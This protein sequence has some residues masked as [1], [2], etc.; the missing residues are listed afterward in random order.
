MLQAHYRETFNFTFEGLQG[1]RTALA[2]IDECIGK[3]REM[4]G[5]I[6]AKP[7]ANSHGGRLLSQFSIALE[8]DLNISRAWAAVFEW[9]RENNSWYSLQQ[10]AEIK[11]I[12]SSPDSIERINEF[13]SKRAKEAAAELTAWEQVNFVL[14][15]DAAAEV[16]APPEIIALLEARQSA[17][18]T[19]DFKRADAIRD[20]LKA[21]GWTIEDTPKGPKLKKL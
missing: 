14:G 2:R 9:V 19:K 3:L 11:S 5:N 21:R 8:D 4:A 10:E 7:E 6:K 18:K 12:D 13:R 20:E 16:E 17:R 1:T 15:I